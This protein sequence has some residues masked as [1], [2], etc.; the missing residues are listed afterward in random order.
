MHKKKR[1]GGEGPILFLVDEG[2]L[3]VNFMRV[4]FCQGFTYGNP[5]VFFLGDI[6]P[7]FNLKNM[8]L[9]YAKEF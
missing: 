3:S 8:I 9:I 6:S 1:A 7:N 4:A 2:W 5:S